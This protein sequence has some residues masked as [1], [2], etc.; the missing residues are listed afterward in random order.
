MV[1]VS[2]IILVGA[3]LPVLPV[4][5]IW[6]RCFQVSKARDILSELSAWFLFATLINFKQVGGIMTETLVVNSDDLLQW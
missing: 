4:W 1:L 3:I 5:D 6:F 2:V